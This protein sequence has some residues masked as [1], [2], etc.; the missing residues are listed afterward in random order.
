MADCPLWRCKRPDMKCE[1]CDILKEYV[2]EYKK[3]ERAG[4]P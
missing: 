1:D 3:S 4:T 2:H